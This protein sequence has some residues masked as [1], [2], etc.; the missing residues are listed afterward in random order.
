ML[1]LD[2]RLGIME[3]QDLIYKAEDKCSKTL[4]FKVSGDFFFLAVV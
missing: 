4:N 3:T 1:V 2:L